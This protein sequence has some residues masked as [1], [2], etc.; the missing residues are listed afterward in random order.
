M[1]SHACRAALKTLL[2]S[3]LQVPMLPSTPP[4]SWWSST[5]GRQLAQLVKLSMSFQQT[6]LRGMLEFG[7]HKLSCNLFY[8]VAHVLFPFLSLKKPTTLLQQCANI[9]YFELNPLI[10]PF[11]DQRKV[12]HLIPLVEGDQGVMASHSAI[13]QWGS[14]SSPTSVGTSFCP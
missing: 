12:L 3:Y 4:F 10:I 13:S 5:S 6:L 8:L 1:L 7:I 14:R 2:S 9:F 11:L